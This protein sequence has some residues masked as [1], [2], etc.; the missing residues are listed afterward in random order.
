[1]KKIFKFLLLLIISF[2]LVG[3][4]EN[5]DN[6]NENEDSIIRNLEFYS[7]NDFHGALF[8]DGE[9]AGIS[10]ISSYL[11]DRKNKNPNN[12]FILSAGDMFQGT[13]VS[14]MTRGRVVVDAM[15]E[16]GFDAM[17][18]GNHEFDWGV[19]E[20]T[21]FYDGNINNGEAKFPL[22]N[23]NIVYKDTDERVEWIDPYTIIEK[24]GVKVGVIGTLGEDQTSDIL[25]SIIEPYRFDSQ[26]DTMKKYAQI[27]RTEENVDIVVAL[28]H[29]NTE[30]FNTRIADLTGNQKID[31]V[32]NGH[33]HYYYSGEEARIDGSKPLPYVQAGNNGKYIGK[34]TIEY[35]T[36]TD[37]VLDVS[38]ENIYALDYAKNTDPAMETILSIYQDQIDI[39]NEVLGTAG[40]NISRSTGAKWAAEVIQKYANTDIGIV[41]YGGI[42]SVGF[43]ISDNQVV[44][45]ANIFKIMPFENMVVTVELTGRQLKEIISDGSDLYYNSELDRSNYYLNGE[46]IY[47]NNL[48]QVATVD[49]VFEQDR[50]PFKD[51]LNINYTDNLFRD[52]LVESVKDSVSKSGKWYII[53]SI[54]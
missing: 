12:V 5:D 44:N 35:N 54:N 47:D 3:C 53:D 22:I 16:I 11:K 6:I 38:A 23:A 26:L 45:Y 1:M 34:I 7:L 4:I 15:N 21:K 9:E 41:N 33:T 49:Y 20:I 32:I 24:N 17:T 8:A 48:Y 52:F 13:A 51:G 37:E 42:R 18:I 31:L 50:F 2:V 36:K 46:F 39:S 30:S 43:P 27:L 29:A 19:G 28:A 10:R 40:E 25:T 14:S